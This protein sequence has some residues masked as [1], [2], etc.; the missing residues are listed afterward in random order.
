MCSNI[1]FVIYLS[2]SGFIDRNHAEISCCF[3]KVTLW[4]LEKAA[5]SNGQLVQNIPSIKIKKRGRWSSLLVQPS[6]VADPM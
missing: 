6:F 3:R 5:I 2:F 1:A 4:Q